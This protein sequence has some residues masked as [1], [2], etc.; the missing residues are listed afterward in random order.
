LQLEGF[1]RKYQLRLQDIFYGVDKSGDGT[2]D[3]QE[4]Q[5]ALKNIKCNIA[6]DKMETLVNFLDDSGDGAV[7]IS[8]LEVRIIKYDDSAC[9]NLSRG[10]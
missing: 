3:G 5:Q 8:E 10:G 9:D 6:D 7:D 1:I 2:L 4:L